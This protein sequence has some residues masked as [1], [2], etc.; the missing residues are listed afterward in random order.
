MPEAFTISSVSRFHTLMILTETTSKSGVQHYTENCLSRTICRVFNKRL[1]RTVAANNGCSVVLVYYQF[2]AY[3]W[4][5][6]HCV[7]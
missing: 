7:N 1:T 2:I 5:A 4:Y 3:T 6:W